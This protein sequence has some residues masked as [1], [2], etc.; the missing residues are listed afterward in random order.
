MNMTMLA[1]AHISLISACSGV[2]GSVMCKGLA[3]AGAKVAV[4]G[5]REAVA[6][7][8]VDAITV[9]PPTPHRILPPTPPAPAPLA[10]MNTCGV[11]AAPSPAR[12]SL[13]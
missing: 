2:L 8:V 5:R 13:V 7:E 11:R 10:P 3:A 6:Q 4:V 12:T 1:F 9:D